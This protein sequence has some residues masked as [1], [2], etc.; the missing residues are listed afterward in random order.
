VSAAAR[1]TYAH[2][3]T[4]EWETPPDFFNPLNAEFGFTLDAAANADNTK[5]PERYFTEAD[6]GL[7]QDWSQDVVWI[8]PPYGRAIK[9]WM[10]KAYEESLRG[11]TV[12]CLVPAHTD[13]AWWWDY[14]LRGDIR[15]IRGRIRFLGGNKE[16]PKGH[17]APFPVAVVIFRPYGS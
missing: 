17:N 6:D 5:V 14:A 3:K 1:A 13:T 15:F 16:N 2:P 12:V 4:V 11:A 7:A 9:L 8:N 10:K